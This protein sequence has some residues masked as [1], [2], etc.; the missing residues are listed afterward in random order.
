MLFHKSLVSLLVIALAS[1]SVTAII[2]LEDDAPSCPSGGLTCCT[3]TVPYYALTYDQ[4][5]ALGQLD[6][7]LD[8]NIPVGIGCYI[9]DLEESGWQG[10]YC[11]PQISF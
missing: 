5:D 3:K 1:T 9:P 4:K 8:T 6:S 2:L 10:W 7:N 11:T